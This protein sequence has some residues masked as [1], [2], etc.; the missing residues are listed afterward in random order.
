MVAT[1][2]SP[3]NG[4]NP[5]RVRLMTAIF[6]TFSLRLHRRALSPII[7]PTRNM[8]VSSGTHLCTV[9]TF[10]EVESL[11]FPLQLSGPTCFGRL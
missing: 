1:L 11:H 5:R 10:L 4:N 8:S 9:A 3:R 7:S 6:G 2:A